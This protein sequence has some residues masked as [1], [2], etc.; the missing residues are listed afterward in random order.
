MYRSNDV[1][2]KMRRTFT[3][4]DQVKFAL[5]SCDHNPIHMDAIAAR[6]TQ[7]GAPVVHGIHALLWVLD[8]LANSNVALNRVNQIRVQF[9][10]FI[11]VG[12]ELEIRQ[13]SSRGGIRRFS[14]TGDGVS[15]MTVT[16][17]EGEQLHTRAP[18]VR[19]PN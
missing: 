8:E 6:R 14:V 5:L 13:G 10:K 2:M 9:S 4:E 12:V 19:G 3:P 15:L 7:A 16:L 18:E 11:Y 17:R 1:E